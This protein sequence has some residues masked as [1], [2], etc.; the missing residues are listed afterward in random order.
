M[1]II[2]DYKVELS[3]LEDYI[4][5]QAVPGSVLRI[6][7]AG[8]GRE[9]YFDLAAI[10]HEITGVDL[11]GEALHARVEDRNDLAHAL[12]ADLRTSD[13]GSNSFDVV[14]NSFVLEHVPGAEQVLR[15][16]VRWLR[17]GGILIIRVPDLSSVQSL[18]ANCFPHWFR[19]LYYRLAWKMKDAGKP[20]TAPY[21]I[22]YDDV[23]TRDGLRSFCATYGLSVQEEIGV[24]TYRNR[25]HGIA[26][27]ATPAVARLL[28]WLTLKRFHDRYVDLTFVLRK[29][30]Q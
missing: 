27:A 10:P 26:R 29:M 17:P 8:C 1:R 11:D 23:I 3:I 2:Q 7:E 24:G 15:N 13:L 20:G 18:I 4:R 19:V 12:V 28:T 25:G 6:L 16:F 22:V 21:P 5:N 30:K 14:Y 9:W